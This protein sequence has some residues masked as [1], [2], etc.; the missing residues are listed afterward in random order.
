MIWASPWAFFLFIPLAIVL[1]WDYLRRQRKTASLQYSEVSVFKSVPPSLRMRFMFLPKLLQM[2]GI[3]FA[4]LALARPQTTNSEVRRDVEGIDI[5]ICL[6]ISDSMMIEDMKPENRLEAAKDTLIKF[7]NGR[8][9]DRI[10]V[11]IFS[12][13]SFTLVPLTLDYHLLKDRISKLTTAQDAHIK[14]GTA[15]GVGLAN[16]VGRLREST[17]KSRIIIFATD[18]GNNSGTIDPDTGIA[19][20]KGYGVKIYSI[21]IGK[22]GPTKIPIYQKDIFGNTVKTYQDFEDPVNVD[23]LTRMATE[24]GGKFF[25][26]DQEDSLPKIFSEI[27][28]LEKSKV[29]QKSYVRYTEQFEKFLWIAIVLFGFSLLLG[30]TYFRRLP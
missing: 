26:A 14:D 16:A 2:A 5:M 3:C 28:H 9:S 12:G 20:A 1:A 24:T 22:D 8:T 23:L 30:K 18:G 21:G 13:E 7:I 10:G 25:R 27:D 17:A 19:I 15:I 11:V 6:D 4:I 29:E